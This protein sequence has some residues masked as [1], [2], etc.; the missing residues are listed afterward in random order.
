MLQ[1]DLRPI[2]VRYG[3]EICYRI[4][5]KC[6]MLSYNALFLC[7]YCCSPNN[8]SG[9]ISSA[10]PSSYNYIIKTYRRRSL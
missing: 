2:L 9:I 4:E 10:S 1:E 3:L 8:L 7:K 5:K 6:F